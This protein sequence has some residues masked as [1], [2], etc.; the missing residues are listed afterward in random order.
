MID[1]TYNVQVDTPLGPKSGTLTMHT[2]GG[3]LTGSLAL[4]GQSGEFSDGTVDGT[5]FRISGK[6]RVLMMPLD[7]QITG[8]VDGDTVSATAATNMGDMKLTGTRA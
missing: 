4:G 1:G 3:T 5:E 8:R 7:Y 6:Q 2:D